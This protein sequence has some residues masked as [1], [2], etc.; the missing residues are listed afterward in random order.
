ME[1]VGVRFLTPRSMAA[2]PITRFDLDGK[3]VAMMG[4]LSTLHGGPD[5]LGPPLGASSSGTLSPSTT[6]SHDSTPVE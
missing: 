4:N 3:L 6:S 2:N 1:T 5:Q